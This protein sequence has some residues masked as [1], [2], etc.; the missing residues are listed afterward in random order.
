MN[1]SLVAERISIG[2]PPWMPS[3]LAA[4]VGRLSVAFRWPGFDHPAGIVGLDVQAANL[5]PLRLSKTQANW[6]W[7]DPAKRRINRHSLILRSLSLP[8]AHVVLRDDVRQLQFAGTI[9]AQDPGGLI[10]AQPLQI[11]GQRPAQRQGR[12]L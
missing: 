3:G 5:Y 12:F 11:E 4:E 8:N 10:R 9:S 6:Q 7:T 1:P 2:N